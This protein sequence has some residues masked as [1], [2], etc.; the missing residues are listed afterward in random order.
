MN[1]RSDEITDEE[2]LKE[3]E[4]SNSSIHELVVVCFVASVLIAFM[5]SILF[6]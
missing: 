2:N 1:F 5:M 4:Q 6:F 3:N